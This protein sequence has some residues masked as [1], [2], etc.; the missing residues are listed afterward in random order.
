[1]RAEIKWSIWAHIVNSVLIIA[2][3][4]F[5][6]IKFD[7]GWAMFGWGVFGAVTIITMGFLIFAVPFERGWLTKKH[8]L[9]RMLTFTGEPNVSPNFCHLPGMILEMLIAGFFYIVFVI[10][11]MFVLQ[12]ICQILFM[13]KIVRLKKDFDG[14]WWP[15]DTPID[16]FPEFY[17]GGVDNGLRVRPW[18]IY[19][20]LFCMAMVCKIAQKIPK[21]ISSIHYGSW[22]VYLPWIGGGILLVALIFILVKTEV[23]RSVWNILVAFEKK[24]CFIRE[25]PDE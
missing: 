22:F 12:N 3:G 18:L 19:L 5:F 6:V 1:M 9:W 21:I 11:C 24:V 23:F 7:G 2:S 15:E 25:I 4:L 14:D 20:G 17:L 10:F 13:G 8:I 16:K